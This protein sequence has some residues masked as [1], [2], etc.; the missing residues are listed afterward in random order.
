MKKFFAAILFSAMFA[1]ATF[2]NTQEAEAQSYAWGNVYVSPTYVQ[3]Q[4]VNSTPYF[5]WCSGRVW[6]IDAWGRW[7][8]SWVNTSVPA[9]Q[10]RT[11][12]VYSSGG[13]PFVRGDANISCRW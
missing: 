8:T 2:A 9:Y 7:V 10:S 3:A 12:Y 4:I 11:V 5:A 1:L 6:G 13:N